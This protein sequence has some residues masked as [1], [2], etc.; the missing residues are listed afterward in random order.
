MTGL[1]SPQ[2]R[3]V[4]D[5]VVDAMVDS[6]DA[7]TEADKMGDGDHGIGMKRGFSA[8]R[9]ALS[10]LEESTTIASIFKTVGSTL[11]NSV[12]GAS[13]VIFGTLFRSGAKEL[14]DVEV[15]D[16]AS[17]AMFVR[18]GLTGVTTRGGAKPGQKTI[19]DALSPA[20][21]A[22]DAAVG[23]GC[24]LVETVQR[25]AAA[26]EAGAEATKQMVATVGRAKTLGERSLGHID[27]GALSTSI[28]FA[29]MRD[30]TVSIV[31]GR[32]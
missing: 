13:G 15:L 18:G 3:T 6:V 30:A 8:V 26:A 22:A 16:S 5:H 12:G 9:D 1:T 25:S 14:G 19:V 4:M 29:A 27:P 21:E 17:F 24:D 28:I 7:L 20:A 2:V 32:T 23:D 31:E 10:A 11:I